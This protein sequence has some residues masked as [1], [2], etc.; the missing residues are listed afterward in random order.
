MRGA[1]AR[2]IKNSPAITICPAKAGHYVLKRGNIHRGASLHYRPKVESEI[3]STEKW[4]TT[5]LL[6]Y[7]YRAA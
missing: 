1:P 2:A 3:G 7:Y 6:N 4:D 5:G